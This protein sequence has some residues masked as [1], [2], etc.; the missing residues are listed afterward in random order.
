MDIELFNRVQLGELNLSG[1][2]HMLKIS[3]NAARR[4]V[5]P[6]GRKTWQVAFIFK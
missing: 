3:C 2:G 5:R 6:I 4:G 1:V